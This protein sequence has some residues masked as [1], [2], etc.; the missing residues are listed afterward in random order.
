MQA[1]ETPCDNQD[2]YTALLES[3]QE[4]IMYQIGEGCGID[5]VLAQWHSNLIGLGEI[6]WIKIR[7]S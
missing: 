1:E 7:L 3:G 5:Q 2:I 6:F 4:E